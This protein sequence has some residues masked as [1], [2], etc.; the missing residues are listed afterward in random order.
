M[1][2]LMIYLSFLTTAGA[3]LFYV[4][5]GEIVALIIALITVVILLWKL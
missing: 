4:F 1:K 2:N 5:S 3:L